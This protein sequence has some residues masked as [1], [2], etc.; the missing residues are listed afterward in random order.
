MLAN[1]LALASVCPFVGSLSDLFGR[2]YVA[3][4]GAS[5]LILG[6][7]V[8]STAQTMNTFICG[9]A[10]AGVG[11]G[12]NELTALAVTSEIAPTSK[13]G[14]Y[15][16]LMVFTIL[17]FCPS[18]LWGQLVAHYATW[19]YIGLWCALWALIGLVLTIVFYHPPP[20]PNN[21]GL[22]R[23]EVLTR[24]DYLGGLLSIS[25]ML[26]FMMGLQW[27]GYNYPWASAHVLVPLIL[28]VVLMALFFLWE[29]RFAPFPMFP[30]RL[31]Q[32]PRL[33][34]LTLIITLISGANFFSVLLF[35]PTQ[36]YNVYGHDPW[37]IGV[38]SI[39][40]GFSILAGACTVLWLLTATKG[41]IRALMLASCI[42]MTA[43]GGA[44]AALNRDN[45]WLCYLVITIAGLGI[46]GIGTFPPPPSPCAPLTPRSR[47][48]LHH[49]H[50]H[51]PRRPHRHR[52]RPHPRH[53]RPR[54]RPRLL[55]LLQRLRRAIHRPRHRPARPRRRRHPA[56]HRPRPSPRRR[57]HH[58]CGSP[59]R[60][61]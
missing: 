9:M 48:R 25:G 50:R 57:R 27:G 44:M 10:L 20:R 36:S 3:I 52:H 35:W 59:R 60:P 2:R 19:R 5:F 33:L 37:A 43:G 49:H 17:P 38:R 53:P 7:I 12:V 56:L 31:N 40:L 51:L 23:K 34:V 24:I 41:H 15:N 26:L 47:P 4:G 14:L 8:C 29:A 54:R 30:R 45:E 6:M 16:A 39:P 32:E 21:A 1:L 13:R 61:R 11:A 42:L 46:G 58:R 22:S 55:H 18:Q 28:G